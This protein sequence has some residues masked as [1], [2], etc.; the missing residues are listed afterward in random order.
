MSKNQAIFGVNDNI[1]AD[2]NLGWKN[3]QFANAP[4]CAF[5]YIRKIRNSTHNDGIFKDDKKN[6]KETCDFNGNKVKLEHDKPIEFEDLWRVSLKM[7]MW[8]YVITTGISQLPRIKEV[9]F[10]K[11]LS[12]NDNHFLYTLSI[13]FYQYRKCHVKEYVSD[14]RQKLMV[15][16]LIDILKARNVVKHV[17]FS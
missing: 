14:I 17:A 8:S 6:R 3:D 4:L 10:I 15:L 7:T 5:E 2:S 12:W 1:G 9:D 11:D 16:I 13:I